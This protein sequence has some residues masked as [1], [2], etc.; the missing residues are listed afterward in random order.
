MASAGV[1]RGCLP[2]ARTLVSPVAPRPVTGDAVPVSRRRLIRGASV[3]RACPI[4]VSTAVSAAREET[5]GLDGR[6][7]LRCGQCGTWR[8]LDVSFWAARRVEARLRHD[9]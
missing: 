6:Y 9:R 7:F 8:S 3:L 4:C 5:E 1:L 2:P